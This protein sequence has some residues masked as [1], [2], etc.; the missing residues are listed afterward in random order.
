[1]KKI[2]K[3]FISAFILTMVS[4]KDNK[5]SN[6]TNAENT[7]EQEAP[8]S[9]QKE[10]TTIA[11]FK[12]YTGKELNDWLPNTILEYVKEPTSLEFGNE[13]LHQIKAYYQ[14]KAGHEKYIELEIT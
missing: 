6:E 13:N 5:S 8:I 14:Y 3:L 11:N 4:C 10:Q 1:M 9:N 2:S 7:S 12:I